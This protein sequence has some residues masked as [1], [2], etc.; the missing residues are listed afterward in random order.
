MSYPLSPTKSM[1]TGCETIRI[2]TSARSSLADNVPSSE[3]SAHAERWDAAV[4][5][6]GD[7]GAGAGKEGVI[8]VAA[9][10]GVEAVSAIGSTIRSMVPLNTSSKIPNELCARTH[11]GNGWYP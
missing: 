6:A 3:P 2:A 5:L 1:I 9:G 8:Q 7:E 11:V 10:F 4:N